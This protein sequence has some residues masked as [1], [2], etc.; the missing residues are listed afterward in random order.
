[1]ESAADAFALTDSDWDPSWLLEALDNVGD[2]A[3]TPVEGDSEAAATRAPPQEVSSQK[4]RKS[5]KKRNYDP[6]KARSE[7]LR[8]LRR[9]RVEAG[10]LQLKMQQLQSGGRDCPGSGCR[11]EEDGGP[12]PAVW[13]DICA[14]QFERRIKAKQENGHLWRKYRTERRLASAIEKLLFRRLA[15]QDVASE[16]GKFV[17]RVEIPAAFVE[18]MADHLFDELAA[19]VELSYRDVENV[20]ETNCPVPTELE[21]R[22][23]LV[24]EGAGDLTI[25]LFDKRL[26]PFGVQESGDAWWRRWQKYRGHQSSECTGNEIRERCGLEMVDVNT[27]KSATFYVQQALRRYV[28]NHR[29]VIVWHAYFEPFTF[30][31]KRVAGVQFL[32]KG[33]VLMCYSL[34]PYFADPKRRKGGR[35]NTLLKFVVSSTSANISISNEMMENMLLDEMLHKRN[36]MEA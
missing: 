35:A 15:L 33:Y 31:E 21:T 25:D 17:R 10:D 7:Q 3:L 13:E 26:M 14:R 22:G 2:L 24:H 4:K 6:N 30:G 16:A 27:D 11:Q 32:L 20:L 12:L 8:E 5:A 28:E 18:N 34:T 36:N 1:M 9:L 19:G 29:V 23:P